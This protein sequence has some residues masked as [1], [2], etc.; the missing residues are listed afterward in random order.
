MLQYTVT[1]F[2]K[3]LVYKRLNANNSLSPSCVIHSEGIVKSAW[4]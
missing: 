1:R 2:E 3:E 4:L